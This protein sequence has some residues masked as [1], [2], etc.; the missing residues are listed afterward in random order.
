MKGLTTAVIRTANQL[1]LFHLLSQSEKPVS[2][3]AIVKSTGASPILLG[4]LLLPQLDEP[5]SNSH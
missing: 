3:D 4:I 2:I 1:K 5:N